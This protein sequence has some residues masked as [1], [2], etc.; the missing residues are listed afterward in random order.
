MGEGLVCGWDSLEGAI[1]HSRVMH[2]G[3]VLKGK[4][5]YS[6]DDV[7]DLIK[8]V[9]A[10]VLE[11]EKGKVAGKFDLDEWEVKLIKR[12]SFRGVGGTQLLCIDV[13]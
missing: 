12:R 3:L 1:P 5:M 6:R 11:L 2:W 7:G 13:C 8:M 10:G 9:E 4:W